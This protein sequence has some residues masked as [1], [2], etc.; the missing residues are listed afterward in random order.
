LLGHVAT[1]VTVAEAWKEIN[2][3]FASQSHAHTIQ[4]R[5]HLAITQKGDL[6]AV[7]YYC[8]M[9]DFAAFADEMDAAGKLLEDEDFVSYVLAG[10]DQDYNSF[11]ENVTGKEEISLGSMYSKLLAVEARLDLQST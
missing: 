1:C 4:L 9:M 7:A 6:S 8:R 3:M 11:V 2:A 10:L 5:T